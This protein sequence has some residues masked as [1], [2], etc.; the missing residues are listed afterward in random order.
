MSQKFGD[1]LTVLQSVTV[2]RVF[3]LYFHPWCYKSVR[4]LPPTCVTSLMN[5]PKVKADQYFY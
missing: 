4:P 2:K 3:Y 1:F 5:A